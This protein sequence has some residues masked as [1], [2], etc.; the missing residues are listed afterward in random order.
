[1]NYELTEK[2]QLLILT[3]NRPEKGNAFH[4]EMILEVTDLFKKISA[5][6][7]YKL[8]LLEGKGKHFCTGADLHWMQS[9]ANISETENVQQMNDLITMYKVISSCPV[10]LISY[11]HGCV[12][13]GG[14][15]LCALSDY[16]IADENAKFCLSEMKYGL[17][18]GALTPFLLQKIGK[19]NFM[20]WALNAEAFESEEA[21]RCGL[22][23]A[24]G[25]RT[26]A[27]KVF[28]QFSELPALALKNLKKS[29]QLCYP[30]LNSYFEQL[31]I[32]SAECRGNEE[33]QHRMLSFTKKK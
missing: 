7:T 24:I 33:G 11:V 10:P 23:S 13:G 18:P 1:M 19:S 6:N 16:V 30:D 3:L 15:G 8:I 12:Y 4:L 22:V 20:K 27:Q 21:H 29:V 31:K 2:G 26:D 5:E 17:L 9:A 32:L 25:N 14:I 28:E